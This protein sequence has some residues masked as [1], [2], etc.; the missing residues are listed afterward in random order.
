MLE[1]T[2]SCES[3]GLQGDQTSPSWGKSVLNVHWKDWCWSPNTLATWYKELTHWK[4]PWCWAGFKAGG[5]GDDRVW[6]GCMT[7]RT[8]WT[9]V[10]ASSRSSWWTVKHGVLQFMESQRV[11]HDWV[12]DL[13]ADFQIICEFSIYM[14]IFN[15]YV[16]VQLCRVLVPMF[17][18]IQ[19]SFSCV[20]NSSLFFLTFWKK[21]VSNIVSPQLV[22]SKYVEPVALEGLLHFTWRKV[23]KTI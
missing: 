23:L 22:K 6:D 9:W 7:S 2:L 3:L 11:R 21:I 14:C 16:D 19:V 20:S 12:T 17:F 4:R 18:N 8:L 10:W 1:R 15:L 13:Y 5:E